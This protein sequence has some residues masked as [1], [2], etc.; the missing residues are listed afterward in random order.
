M[1]VETHLGL[2]DV[3]REGINFIRGWA[4]VPGESEECHLDTKD[5]TGQYTHHVYVI[6]GEA[7]KRLSDAYGIPIQRERAENESVTSEAFEGADDSEPPEQLP[8]LA[9]PIRAS[10][11]WAARWRAQEG[12]DRWM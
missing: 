1:M 12:L 2:V 7:A 5:R 4:P 10:A 11:S 3:Q 8:R 9:D 6:S